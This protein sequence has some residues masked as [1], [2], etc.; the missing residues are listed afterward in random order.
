MWAEKES[1]IKK[2]SR[3]KANIEELSSWYKI[4]CNYIGWKE[5]RGESKVNDDSVQRRGFLRYAQQAAEA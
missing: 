3:I 4:W 5:E 2:E 1:Q